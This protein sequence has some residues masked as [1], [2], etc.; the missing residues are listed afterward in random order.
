MDEVS[1]P[2]LESVNEVLDILLARDI[3][4]I[5]TAR[6]YANSEERLGSVHADSR[7]AIDSKLPGGFQLEPTTPETVASTLKKTLSLLQTDQVHL[8]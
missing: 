3:K 1:Y 2:T 4:N 5:D 8:C 7:F 6:I